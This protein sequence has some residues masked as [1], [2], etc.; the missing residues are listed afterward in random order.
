MR[1]RL[2]CSSSVSRVRPRKMAV[3][4]LSSPATYQSWSPERLGAVPLPRTGRDPLF[5]PLADVVLPVHRRGSRS[6]GVPQA[7]RREQRRADLRRTGSDDVG[8]PT[9]TYCHRGCGAASRGAVAVLDKACRRHAVANNGSRFTSRELGLNGPSAQRTSQ[10]SRLALAQWTGGPVTM[11][12]TRRAGSSSRAGNLLR[13]HAVAGV[14]LRPIAECRCQ[15]HPRS[16][17]PRGVRAAPDQPSAFLTTSRESKASTVNT[18][19]GTGNGPRSSD[20][21]RR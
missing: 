8:P 6:Q 10:W 5:A 17:G 3:L 14:C 11:H 1:L 18:I 15:V 19:S 21:S 13:R 9:S 7:C 2:R 16:K 4:V 12:R 20:C